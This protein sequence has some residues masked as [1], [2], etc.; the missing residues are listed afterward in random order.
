MGRAREVGVPGMDWAGEPGASE[1]V[2]GPASRRLESGGAGL[3]DDMRRA[4]RSIFVTLL[5][6]LSVNWPSFVL[7][8]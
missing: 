3:L 8:L 1:P 5:C 6:W 7:K 4:G 2:S